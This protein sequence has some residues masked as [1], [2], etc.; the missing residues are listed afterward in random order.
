MA[1]RIKARA[2]RR[3]GELL[4]QIEPSKTGPKPELERFGLNLNRGGFP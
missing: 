1:T 4:K 3:A 2:V